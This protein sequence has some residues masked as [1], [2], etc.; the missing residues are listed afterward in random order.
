MFRRLKHIR[1]IRP[2]FTKSIMRNFKSLT[3]KGVNPQSEEVSQLTM[4]GV[5]MAPSYK[6]KEGEVYHGFQCQRIEDVSEFELVSYTMRHLST[7]TEF[8]YIDRNDANNVFSVHFRTPPINNTGLTHILEHIAMDGSN[9]FPIRDPF[10]KML[11]R[12]V[13]TNQNAMSTTD[14]TNFICASRNEVDF[15]NLQ[16][17]YLDSAFGPLLT[18]SNFTQDGWRI[19]HKDVH[20]RQSELVI[21][22]VVYNEMIGI[23]SDN[24]RILRRDL[25]KCILPDTAYH[26]MNGGDPLEIPDLEHSDLVQYY[27]KY[28]HPSNGRIFCYGSFDPMKSLEYIDKEYFANKDAIDTAFSHIPPHPRWSEPRQIHVPCRLDILGG[29]REKQNQ[30]SIA[31]LMCDRTDVQGTFEMNVLTELLIRGPNSA[32]YKGLIEPNFSGGFNKNTGYF[33]RCRDTYFLVGLQDLKVEDFARFNE[34]YEQTVLKIINE[35][36]EPHHVESVLH[37]MEL[38]VKHQGPDFGCAVFY[39]SMSLWNHGGDIVANLRVMDNIAKLRSSLKQNKHYLQQKVEEYFLKNTH[40][41]TITMSADESYEQNF[42]KATQ[43]VLNQ[44]LKNLDSDDLEAIYQNGLKLKEEQNLIE[45][46]NCLP[47]LTLQD[48]QEPLKIPKIWDELIQGVPTQLCKVPTNGITYF[49][50]FLNT[51]GFSEDDIMLVPLFCDII[52]NCGTVKHNFRDFDKLLRSKTSGIDL[53]VKVVE[54]VRDYKQ[55]RMGMLMSTYALDK[56]VPDMFALCEELM[57]NFRIV[58]TD[59]LRMLI[60]NYISKLSVGILVSG[61]LYAIMGAAALVSDAAKLKSHLLGVDHIDFM[62]NYIQEYSIE[63]IRDKLCAIGSRVFHKANMRVAINSSEAQ[64]PIV[65]EHYQRYLDRLPSL[66][67]M[68]NK[69]DLHLLKPSYHQYEMNIALNYCSKAF[70]AVPYLHEDHPGLRV[71]AKLLTA[72]Y[73]WRVVREQNGAY[74]TNARIGYDGLFTFNSYRDPHSTKTLEV[75]DGCYDWLKELG[76]KLDEEMLLEAK[77]GVLQLVD[78]PIP[79]GETGLDYFNVRVSPQDYRK[80]R[81]R[82]LSVTIDELRVIIDKYFKQE[83]KHFGKCIL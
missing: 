9:K 14:L 16:R 53:K 73:L 33:L 67:K 20:D 7:G 46:V 2:S 78:W 45:D 29:S 3:V 66:E 19:E 35:G 47:C 1:A 49:Y 6:Y 72:K 39:T 59:R 22:G 5:V 23:F 62:K 41:L 50:S 70:Y 74:G 34:L 80:Y 44:K 82:A 71:L 17:I 63:E 13:G 69:T 31:L 81:A 28:F 37:N 48:V 83:P 61:H 24:S 56:N 42:Q 25:L 79:P 38:A 65:L 8:W 32:F 4:P 30:I 10:L 51:T 27:N 75:F 54:N 64:Q 11:N 18:Y 76:D 40:K 68:K 52:Q 58:D 55:Y 26:Y 43:K 36:F 77:L 57:L 12:S 60:K 21:K 15:R